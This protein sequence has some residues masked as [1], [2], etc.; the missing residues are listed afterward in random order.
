MYEIAFDLSGSLPGTLFRLSRDHWSMSL[1]VQK[2]VGGVDRFIISAIASTEPSSASVVDALVRLEVVRLAGGGDEV[3]ADRPG[4]AGDDHALVEAVL[5]PGDDADVVGV[6]CHEHVRADLRP[7]ERRLH[8]VHQHVQVG[9]ALQPL[10]AVADEAADRDV[11]RGDAG[12][13]ER[14]AAPTAGAR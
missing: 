13:V 3:A 5:D 14:R 11:S 10:L 1:I 4:H 2:P 12:D 8:D 9:R 6:A 7:V